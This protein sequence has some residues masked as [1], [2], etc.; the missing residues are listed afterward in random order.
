MYLITAQLCVDW[1]LAILVLSVGNRYI[2]HTLCFVILFAYAVVK[3]FHQS[4][5]QQ[6][7]PTRQQLF[8]VVQHVQLK[9]VMYTKCVRAHLYR[10]RYNWMFVFFRIFRVCEWYTWQIYTQISHCWHF[11]MYSRSEYLYNVVVCMVCISYTTHNSDI[12]ERWTFYAWYLSRVYMQRSF[13]VHEN[14]IVENP[15]QY[16]IDCREIISLVFHEI[17]SMAHVIGEHIFCYGC[18]LCTIICFHF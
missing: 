2:S 11:H 13:F 3:Q 5:P 17:S 6:S 10:L 8:I 12:I 1:A 18:P 4:K 16:T 9:M 7:W 15:I 14:K